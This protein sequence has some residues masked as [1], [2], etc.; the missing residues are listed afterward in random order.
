MKP[1]LL[2]TPEKIY[3][4]DE[5]GKAAVMWNDLIAAIATGSCEC[6]IIDALFNV[7]AEPGFRRPDPFLAVRL[8]CVI[9]GGIGQEALIAQ[10]VQSEPVGFVFRLTVPFTNFVFLGSLILLIL[11]MI[12]PGP[13]F[14]A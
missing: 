4:A 13:R 3:V 1:S 8:F 10:S 12:L 11:H 2:S 7:A 9:I 14:N 5:Q 6:S